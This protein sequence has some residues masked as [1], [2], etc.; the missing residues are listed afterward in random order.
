MNRFVEGLARAFSMTFRILVTVV[1]VIFLIALLPVLNRQLRIHPTD[2]SEAAV[3]TWLSLLG[4]A[5]AILL[6]WLAWRVLAWLFRLVVAAMPAF[7]ASFEVRLIGFGIVVLIFPKAMVSLLR[8]PIFMA[9]RVVAELPRAMNQYSV[10]SGSSD[11]AISVDIAFRRLSGMLQAIGMEVGRELVMVV[12]GLP[13]NE[14]VLALALWVL[15]GQLLSATAD[16]TPGQ[17]MPRW[18]AIVRSL[19]EERKYA[20]ALSTVFGIGVYLSIAAIVAIPWLIEDRAVQGPTRDTLQKALEYR[21]MKPEVFESEF[22]ATLGDKNPLEA[23]EKKVASLESSASS[24][25]KDSAAILLAAALDEARMA[26]SQIATSRGQLLDDWKQVR[27]NVFDDQRR[28]VSGALSAFETEIQSGMSGQERVAFY[29]DVQRTASAQIDQLF[30]QARDCRRM[31][32]EMDRYLE[33]VVAV[34]MGRELDLAA[35]AR[36]DDVRGMP[37]YGRFRG[38]GSLA[39][40]CAP[41]QPVQAIYSPPEPGSGWGPF[42]AMAYWLLRTKSQALALITGMLGF[43]LL[44]A[45]ISTFVRAQADGVVKPVVG[46]VTKVVIRGF[47]AAV[48]VFLAVKGGLAIF[49]GN[50]EQEPNPY[51]LFLT[52]L[53]GAVYSEDVWRW[54]RKKFGDTFPDDASVNTLKKETEA[55]DKEAPRSDAQAPAPSQPQ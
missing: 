24:D 32:S 11:V 25:R 6:I 55:A 47:S 53:I 20:I 21:M 37:S 42:G 52:C 16:G 7:G 33:K 22:P 27:R 36:A 30:M 13:L 48:V 10:G 2:F 23:V 1:L 17:A 12:D 34:D 41:S 14:V 49:A 54:A 4:L 19:S 45:A 46:E 31:V 18:Q 39:G 8:A 44:G 40:K 15:I 43:G 3:G 29:R 5:I 26:L 9:Q 35:Q 28:V 50:G 38:Y 51:V